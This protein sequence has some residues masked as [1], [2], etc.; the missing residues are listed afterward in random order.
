VTDGKKQ[1]L[2]VI[3]SNQPHC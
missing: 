3:R 2:F 1:E